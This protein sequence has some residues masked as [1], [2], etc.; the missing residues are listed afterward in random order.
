MT[1]VGCQIVAVAVCGYKYTH[2]AKAKIVIKTE[3]TKQLARKYCKK[4]K[5]A[6]NKALM[7]HVWHG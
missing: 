1:E 2:S 3:T 7:A 5:M 6:S 4:I